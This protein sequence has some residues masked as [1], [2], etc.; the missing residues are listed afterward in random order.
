[1]KE[2]QLT[3]NL[4]TIVDDTDYASLSKHKWFLINCK[5][6]LYASR[7]EQLGRGKA[8]IVRMHREIMNVSDGQFVIHK[9]DDTLDNRR[10]NLAVVALSVVVHRNRIRACSQ[11]EYKGISYDHGK[12]VAE[13]R[14]N[15]DKHYL[16]RFANPVDAALAY[17]AAA[18][19]YFGEFARLN[20]P[21]T[22][23]IPET[24]CVQRSNTLASVCSS[25]QRLAASFFS[26]SFAILQILRQAQDAQTIRKRFSTSLSQAGRIQNLT[27]FW[28]RISEIGTEG[29]FFSSA[30]FRTPS[31]LSQLTSILFTKFRRVSYAA[32]SY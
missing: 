17:D 18:K 4:S 5:G 30:N 15:G 7:N 28:S 8:R 31:V 14:Q 6:F 21:D 11:Q 24:A 29:E 16:G 2:I 25:V 10:T 32:S 9:N 3:Q 26:S 13:I 22:Q 23:P 20:F 19:T 27:Q 12:Y 1:M